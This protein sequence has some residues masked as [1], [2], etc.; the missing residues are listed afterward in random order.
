MGRKSVLRMSGCRV[1]Q[2][3]GGRAAKGSQS[4][5]G[6]IGGWNIEMNGRRLQSVGGS[7]DI[8]E[9]R[10]VWR[11]KVMNDLKGK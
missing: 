3:P 9:F 4:H 10:E 6:L 5:S 8:Q 11:S 1:F 2:L 7:I